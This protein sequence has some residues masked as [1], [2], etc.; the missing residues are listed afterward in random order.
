V[1]H[2]VVPPLHPKLLALIDTAAPPD[3]VTATL[4]WLAEAPPLVTVPGD[5][6]GDRGTGAAEAAQFPPPR[7]QGRR[8]TS[9]TLTVHGGRT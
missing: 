8:R 9:G 6:D 2:V 7:A 5:D 4:R 3:A 1:S